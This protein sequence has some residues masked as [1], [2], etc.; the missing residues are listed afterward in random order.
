M[1]ETDQF[2]TA[3]KMVKEQFGDD[4]LHGFYFQKPLKHIAETISQYL[5]RSSHIDEVFEDDAELEKQIV[6]T[7]QKFNPDDLH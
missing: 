7:I 1:T 2:Q 5:M 4:V 3:K 6:E